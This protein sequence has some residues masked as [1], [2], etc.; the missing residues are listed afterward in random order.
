MADFTV[1]FTHKI[2]YASYLHASFRASTKI[3]KRGVSADIWH[4]SSPSVTPKAVMTLRR[5]EPTPP[6]F[7]IHRLRPPLYS[8]LERSRDVCAT[9]IG[10]FNFSSLFHNTRTITTSNT[11]ILSNTRTVS[12]NREYRESYVKKKRYLAHP[13]SV[14]NEIINYAKN[15]FNKL[16]DDYTERKW[17]N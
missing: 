4:S 1:L 15:F 11:S 10:Y 16:K 5:I 8:D 3:L 12:W 2:K 9:S 6:W 13:I 17:Y 7:T 14:L